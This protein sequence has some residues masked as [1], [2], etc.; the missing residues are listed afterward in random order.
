M[1]D[2]EQGALKVALD[3]INKQFGANSV[4]KLGDTDFDRAV[5]KIST[6]SLSIDHALGIGGVP[7]G[8]IIEIYGPEGSGKT[9]LCLSILAN[10]QREDAICAFVDTEHALD[11]S[12]AQKLGADPEELIVSQP[13][14]AEQALQIVEML[15]RSGQVDVIVVDSVAALTPAAEIEGEMGEQKIGM[16]ARL[17]SQAMRK[18]AGLVHKTNSCLIFTNQIR[19]KI[20][21]MFG[22]P[23]TTPGGNALKFFASQRIDIR[24]VSPIKK[25]DEIVGYT[26]KVKV[27]KNRMAPPFRV[28]EFSLYFGEG[29]SLELDLIN[30]GIKSG[31]ITKKGAWV[32][33]GDLSIGQGMDNAKRFLEENPETRADIEKRLRLHYGL[34]NAETS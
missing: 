18:L 17:M 8:R 4:M 21:V 9:T 2:K 15:L 34:E 20:G 28:A 12:Y 22:N 13:D 29:V 1:S 32:Y 11:P 24:R 16:Q 10:A 26:G 6:G 3:Q 23:E 14:N 19:Y 27:V 7:K 25:G 31:L 30:M 5:G 33:Y